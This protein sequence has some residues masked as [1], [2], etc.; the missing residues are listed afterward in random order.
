MVK[1]NRQWDKAAER[2]ARDMLDHVLSN[3]AETGPDGLD[4]EPEGAI[5]ATVIEAIQHVEDEQREYYLKHERAQ[6]A[7]AIKMVQKKLIR[8]VT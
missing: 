8:S 4:H 1:E 2:V 3:I 6:W 5:T 7:Q